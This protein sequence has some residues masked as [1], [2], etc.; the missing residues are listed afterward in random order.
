VD[1]EVN[2][3]TTFRIVLPATLSTF[4][5]VTVRAGGQPF[6]FPATGV[7]HVMRVEPDAIRILEGVESINYKSRTIS[8]VW[9]EHVLKIDS[10]FR[11]AAEP[12]PIVIAAYGE[13]RIAFAVSAI[14]G[15][16]EVLMKS[17]GKQL[18]R[19]PNISSAA[20]L[21]A[22][23]VALILNIPDLMKSALR[24]GDPGPAS[25]V[26]D[27]VSNGKAKSALVVE[28]SITS[29][30]A[31]QNIL[32]SA[33][34][35]VESASDGVEAWACLERGPFDLVLSDIDMPRMNGL[36]LTTRIRATREFAAIPVVLV[37]SLESPED[38]ERGMGVGANAYLVK[39]D[40][41]RNRLLAVL[42]S[43]T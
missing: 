8:L 21:G 38:R 34:F 27:G 20:I 41:D 33:G 3:G 32:E 19:V 22:G 10:P 43:L 7:E 39:R 36:E 31:L 14:L 15:E 23:G 42:R 11:G 29:R 2:A 4:R 1:S 28:D 12:V 35:R 40:F 6:V 37:T 24:S 5:G 16:Q 9:L 13:E 26:K 18:S 25:T 30:T 17:L